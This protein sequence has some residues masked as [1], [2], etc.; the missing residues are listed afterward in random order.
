[1]SDDIQTVRVVSA[2]HEDGYKVINEADFDPDTHAIFGMT[3]EGM[4]DEGG[5]IGSSNFPAVIDINGMPVQLGEVVRIAFEASGMTANK[6]NK[7]SEEKRDKIILSAV[8]AL[9]AQ[10]VAE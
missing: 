6:W 1:M 8:E 5:L 10:S 9:R 4:K 2:E 7:A 3:P